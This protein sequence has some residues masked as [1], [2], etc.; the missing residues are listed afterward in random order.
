LPLPP[1]CR[2]ASIRSAR[3]HLLHLLDLAHWG[4]ENGA[5]SEWPQRNRPAVELQVGYLAGWAP[6]DVL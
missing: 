4:Q 5:E 2:S 1:T 3:S 6:A